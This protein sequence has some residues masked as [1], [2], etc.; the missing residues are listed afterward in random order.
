LGIDY[1]EILRISLS[2]WNCNS[3]AIT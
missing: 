2:F 1:R 3:F